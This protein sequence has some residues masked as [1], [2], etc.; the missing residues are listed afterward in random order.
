MTIERITL[1]DRETARGGRYDVYEIGWKDV[2]RGLDGHWRVD[3]ER[4]AFLVDPRRAIPPDTM[5]TQDDSL[6]RELPV[7]RES[8]RPGL[9]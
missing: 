1:I 7:P 8:G 4:G 2:T 9:G 5:A 6:G 3:G